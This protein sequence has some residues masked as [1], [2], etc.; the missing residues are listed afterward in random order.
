LLLAREWDERLGLGQ[1]LL[2]EVERQQKLG[3]EVWF[4]SAAPV[5]SGPCKAIFRS[6]RAS[7]YTFLLL[8]SVISNRVCQD[9]H[10][11]FRVP[12]AAILCPLGKSPRMTV[13]VGDSD[14]HQA[15]HH[16]DKETDDS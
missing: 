15:H 5:L 9:E 12:F 13:R 11:R 1:L 3:K 2:P 8:I 4:P 10:S 6:S 16:P 7:A 14:G